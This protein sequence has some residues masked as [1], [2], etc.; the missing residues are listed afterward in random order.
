M[1]LSEDQLQRYSRH[2]ILP[3]VGVAGQERLLAAKIFIVG[4]GGLGSPVAYYL[5][6]AGIGNL[7]IIDNDAVDLSNLQRQILYSTKT[8]GMRKVHSAKAVLE[9]LNPDAKVNP[10][11]QRLTKDNISSLIKDYDIIVDCSDN[12]STRFLVNDACVIQKKRLVSGAI[13]G[14]EGQLTTILPAE[15]GHCYRC[16]FEDMPP[17][18]IR[19]ALQTAGLVGAIPGVIGTL[20]ALEVIKLIVGAGRILKERLLIFDGLSAKFRRIKVRRNPECP[21]CGEHPR[22]YSLLDQD[23]GAG[24]S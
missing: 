4:A 2:I 8:L 23:Y 16:I 7:G 18:G 22:I 3:E 6:A 10:I 12:F 21:V 19:E 17:A 1:A 20:Q 14:F 11:Q 5:A 15:G 24:V 13:L 9:A